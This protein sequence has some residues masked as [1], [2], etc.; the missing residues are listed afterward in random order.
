LGNGVVVERGGEYIDPQQHTIRRICAELRLPLVPHGINFYRRDD[1]TGEVASPDEVSAAMRAFHKEVGRFLEGDDDASLLEVL[2]SGFGRDWN[3]ERTMRRMVTSLAADPSRVSARATAAASDF[4]VIDAAEAVRPLPYL[5]HGSR[6]LRGN[7][8]IAL[9]LARRLGDSVCLNRAIS[10]VDVR[11]DGGTLAFRDG[12]EVEG[13]AVILALPLP[14]AK[15]LLSGIQL[16]DPMTQALENRFMGVA[17]KFSVT[18]S[19]GA[20]PRGV[21]APSSHWWAW[22]SASPDDSMSVPGVTAFAGGPQTLESLELTSVET[23]RNELAK[24]RPDL[25]LGEE[26]VLTDWRQDEWTGG[27]YSAPGTGWT[28]EFDRVLAEPIGRLILAGEYT[29]GPLASSMNGALH[30][31]ERAAAKVLQMGMN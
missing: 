1:A 10:A 9:E 31:G 21:Q 25:T 16:P 26:C 5:E 14:V 13:D 24:L 12:A 30:S 17:A 8:Q 6:V 29:A 22:N 7:Q 2:E 15:Q 11:P 18:I 19:E 4:G 28:P 3:S 27:S 23:W 20:P